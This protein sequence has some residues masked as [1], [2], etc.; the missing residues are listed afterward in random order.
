[1]KKNFTILCTMLLSLGVFAQA[2][3]GATAGLNMANVVGE[4]METDMKMGMHVG[5][6]AAFELS[7]AMTLKTGALYS[8]KGAEDSED[9]IKVSMNLSYIE[10]P[11][12]LSFAISD[13]MSLMVGPYIGLLMGAEAEIS[14]TG[15][16]FDGTIDMKDDTNAMDFGVNLGAGFAVTEAISI[17]A[18]YQM[19]LMPIDS[20]G[21]GDAKN[22]NIHIGLTYNFGGGY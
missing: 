7:D 11:L 10:I 15:G 9:G 1:M 22:S 17:N 4:D 20:E 18:G 13:Q 2:Q 16:L 21:D 5:V 8:T 3:F 19:G 12:N 14:G 6:S